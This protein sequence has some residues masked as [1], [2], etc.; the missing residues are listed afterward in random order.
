MPRTRITALALVALTACT[1][2]LGRASMA[3]PVTT[4][5]KDCME[6]LDRGEECAAQIPAGDPSRHPTP[7]YRQDSPITRATH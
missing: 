7:A 1:Q 6:R 5:P 3:L 4:V 2:E